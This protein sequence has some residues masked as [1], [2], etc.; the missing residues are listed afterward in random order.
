MRTLHMEFLA[1]QM[2]EASCAMDDPVT[3][4]PIEGRRIATFRNLLRELI[5][6]A[7]ILHIELNGGIVVEKQ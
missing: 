1:C 3:L 7:F 6:L 4:L 2:L 5:D